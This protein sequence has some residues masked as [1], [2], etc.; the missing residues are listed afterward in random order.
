MYTACSIASIPVITKTVNSL[1]IC[2][3][4]GIIVSGCCT[5]PMSLNC[6]HFTSVYSIF[7][8]GLKALSGDVFLAFKKKGNI[9]ICYKL[10]IFYH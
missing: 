2:W 3:V 4:S 10:E 8:D 9:L 5:V 1:V 6:R 7:S